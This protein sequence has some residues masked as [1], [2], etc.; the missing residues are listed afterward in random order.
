MKILAAAAIASYALIATTVSAD[1]AD[2]APW[3]YKTNDTSMAAPDQWAEHYSTCGGQ[4]QS[5]INIETTAG[6]NSE[7]R[8]LTFSGSCGDFN[9]AQSDESF[10]ASV[11]GGSCAVSANG[12]S[13][14]MLQFHMHV[15]SEHTLNGEHLG[16]DV[17]FVHSNADSSAL[18]VTGVLFKAVEG[19]SDPWVVSVLNAL[20]NVSTNAP[21]SASLASYA[22]LVNKAADTE[23]VFNYAGSLT[24]PACSEIVDWWVVKKPVDVSTADLERLQSQLR[25]LHITDD[26]KNA[27]PVQPL[28]GRVVTALL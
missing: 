10:M 4:R 2:G 24:S 20:D 25:E 14:N 22:D 27:R 11:N 6:S 3:G 5:P 1:G 13:Y 23:G 9:V 17:H 16:G 28:N 18:L 19:E 12:A 7:K 26:G 8:S 21:A 15:P